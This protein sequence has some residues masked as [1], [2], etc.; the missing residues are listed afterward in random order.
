MV[1]IDD[2]DLSNPNKETITAL[3][4]LMYTGKGVNETIIQ[5]LGSLD[6]GTID[7]LLEDLSKDNDPDLRYL[8]IEAAFGLHGEGAAP[9]V[10]R[11]LQDDFVGNRSAACRFIIEM[12]NPKY[13]PFL[14][15]RLREDT[16]GPVRYIAATGLGEI[17]DMT[18]LDAL[19]YAAEHDRGT[20]HEGREIKTKA[21]ESIQEIEARLGGG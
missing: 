15:G 20:D 18:C 7:P 12:N 21:E 11:L 17:G 14:V 3:L 2:I 6:P 13:L 8:A 16:E 9:A 4:Q 19:R 1:R 10:L 5:R